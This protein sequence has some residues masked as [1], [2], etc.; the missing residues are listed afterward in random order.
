L[1]G[2][3]LCSLVLAILGPVVVLAAVVFILF[4]I[5][6]T[7]LPWLTFFIGPLAVLALVGPLGAWLG[8]GDF[9]ACSTL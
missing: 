3:A 2:V 9:R 1:L 5:E 7:V 6:S 4:S 8:V